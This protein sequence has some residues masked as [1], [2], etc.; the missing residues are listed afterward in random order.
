MMAYRGIKNIAPPILNLS[1]RW[2]EWSN[3]RPGRSTP[4]WKNPFY[5]MNRRVGEH[6]SRYGR[7]RLE[8]NI[9]PPE[10]EGRMV[11]LIA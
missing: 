7:F 4:R 1:S 3:S 11:Q 9:C 2:T 8:K 5:S 6:Q 10:T